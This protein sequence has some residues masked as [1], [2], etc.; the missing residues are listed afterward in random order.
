[1]AYFSS[2]GPTSDGRIKPDV[3][4][5]GLAAVVASP[6]GGASYQNGTSFATPITAG[7]VA[8]L[9]QADTNA[10]NYQ[11]MTAIKQSATRYSSPND[12]IGWGVPNYCLARSIVLGITEN[13]PVS[14]LN[15]AYP[16]PF[17]GNITLSF[18]SSFNQHVTISLY[19]ML[20]QTIYH[21]QRQVAG[22]GNTIVT[23]DNLQQLPK[24]LYLVAVTDEHGLTSTQKV[25]KE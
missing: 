9:W 3:V 4:A 21:E 8:C 25:V 12:S 5:C 13:K 10:S 1:Y 7:A 17:T 24:G 22:G 14:I 19:N 6:Y 18:F 16:D 20:G 11:I 15:K 23:I 2:M